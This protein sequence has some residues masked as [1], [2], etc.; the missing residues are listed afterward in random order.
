[1]YRLNEVR[2]G[3]ALKLLTV[4][5]TNPFDAYDLLGEV[6]WCGCEGIFF[7]NY[8]IFTNVDDIFPT[9]NHMHR[10]PYNKQ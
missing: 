4:T 5:L 6:F 1:M 2:D 7:T 3:V 8:N 10:L 9:R